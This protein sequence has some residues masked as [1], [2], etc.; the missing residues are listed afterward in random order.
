MK[1]SRY[2]IFLETSSD[3][4][5]VFNAMSKKFFSFSAKNLP[6]L[7]TIF[8]SPNSYFQQEEYRNFLSVMKN[9]GFLIEDD[10]DEVRTTPHTL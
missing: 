2:N 9:N 4:T 3:E 8:E 10:I 6:E 1:K 5:L 7:K